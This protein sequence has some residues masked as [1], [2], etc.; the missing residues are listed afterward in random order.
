M[1][2]KYIITTIL[3]LTFSTS[4]FADENTNKDTYEKINQ[5]LFKSA[6]E[7]AILVDQLTKAVELSALKLKIEQNN[8]QIQK[9]RNSLIEDKKRI[10]G[11]DS[12]VSS[13]QP[14]STPSF[15]SSVNITK[16][17]NKNT[18]KVLM[19][20]SRISIDEQV[21]LNLVYGNNDFTIKLGEKLDGWRFT[22]R[23]GA[24]IAKKKNITKVL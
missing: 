13:Q 3:Y 2:I 16:V 1:E 24:V 5:K 9:E 4:I 12:N 23:D 20:K 6:S 18:E 8:I 15:I 10:E 11:E 17:K 21:Y 14:I 7:H 22:L 19:L